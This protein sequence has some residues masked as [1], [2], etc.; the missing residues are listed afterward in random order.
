MIK[1]SHIDN[2]KI[3][4]FIGGCAGD[5]I[6]ALHNMNCFQELT[7]E[8][9][10]EI[11]KDLLVLQKDRKDMTIE[12]KDRYLDKHPIISCCDTKFALRHRNKTLAIKCDSKLVSDYLCKR[13][14]Q[15]HP[16][17]QKQTSMEDYIKTFDKWNKFWP[18]KFKKTLDM[19]DIFDNKNFLDKLDV[20]MDEEKEALFE[21][22]RSIN[23]KSFVVHKEIY[24]Q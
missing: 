8:G 18:S 2:T 7:L 5:L 17:L 23:E 20:K 4:L 13:Y 3:V 9:K 24:D 21:R 11:D 22:W 16:R 6:T 15:Y 10:I 19:Y 1:K 14:F 12:D